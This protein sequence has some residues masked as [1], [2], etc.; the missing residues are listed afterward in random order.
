MA[1]VPDTLD[2]EQHDALLAYLRAAGY[3]A[4]H[5][6]ARFETLPGGV[7]SRTVLVRRPTPPDWVI[8]QSL[9]KLRVDVPWYSDPERIHREALGIRWLS[10]HAPPS[11]VPP[12]VFED[13]EHHLLAMEA[14]PQPHR[15]WKAVLLSGALDLEHVRQFGYLLGTIHRRSAERRDD[16]VRE[17]DDRSFFESLRV[18][19]YY[20]FTASQVPAAA[21]F[22]TQLIAAVRARR[23]TLVHGDYSPKNI[24]LHDGRLVLLD[25]EVMHFGDPAFDLGFSFAHLLSKAHHVR[26]RRQAFA[27]AAETYWRAYQ[28][29]AGA[30][31]WAADLEENAVRH[32][33][34][35][36]LARVA[37]R[38]PLEYLTPAER[39]Q[40]GELVVDLMRETPRSIADL[41]RRFTSALG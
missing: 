24:L 25:H 41:V 40:Q 32:T 8:K 39:A 11:A 18:E 26:S 3:I 30:P 10:E 34:G 2:I 4:H 16:V 1:T 23:L 5:E 35:C 7:S 21:S 15:N 17:F 22:L 37:G 36:L 38:S 13:H 14:V 19:P 31:A 20:A 28:E 9:A 6:C 29:T 12:L 33:L 27:S